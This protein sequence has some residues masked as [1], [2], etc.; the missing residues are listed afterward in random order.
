MLQ[1]DQR[2]E[3]ADL[4]GQFRLRLVMEGNL[5]PR[6]R[7]LQLVLEGAPLAQLEV[8][9][10]LKKANGPAAFRLRSIERGICVRHQRRG[11]AAV[12]RINGHPDA[13]S[14]LNLLAFE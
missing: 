1:T 4:D 12:G 5:A 11:V 9:F 10:G 2:V 13:P 3:T 6:Q 14:E 8:H 7:R